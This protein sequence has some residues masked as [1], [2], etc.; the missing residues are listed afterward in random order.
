MRVGVVIPAH[1]EQDLLPA[2]LD[3]LAE[4][5]R[6][7][8][9]SLAVVLDNCTDGSASLCEQRGIVPVTVAVR[10]AGR[11]RA[12]GFTRLLE[13][14]GTED[15]WLASTDADSRV[16]AD[17]LH[18]QLALAEAGADAVFGVVDVEDWDEHPPAVADRF[19]ALYAGTSRS[20]PGPHPHRHGA[21][22]GLRATTYL[23]VG[24]LPPLAV[25]ED[26]ALSD[27]LV[28]AGASVVAST[29]VRVV[30]S[31]RAR[32]RVDGGFASFLRA[33]A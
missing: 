10:S 8:D 4:A 29:A 25:G 13:V 32:S 20:D 6:G 9:A 16:A 26:Q 14:L 24:G 18:Q 1:D 22:F 11:A 19:R 21:C 17:W 15:V 27:L 2:C 5:A 3:A 30:T 12:E 33:L 7:V 31:S 28:R 23:E